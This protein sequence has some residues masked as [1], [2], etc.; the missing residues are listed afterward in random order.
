VVYDGGGA[1]GVFSRGRPTASNYGMHVANGSMTMQP[2]AKDGSNWFGDISGGRVFHFTM[3][4][5]SHLSNRRFLVVLLKGRGQA[6]YNAAPTKMHDEDLQ[7]ANRATTDA[8]LFAWVINGSNHDIVMY[9]NNGSVTGRPYDRINPLATG[10]YNDAQAAGRE[11]L[12]Q[13]EPRAQGTAR[14]HDKMHRFHLYVSATRFRIVEETPEGIY[15]VVVERDF[16]AGTVL[17]VGDQIE[18]VAVQ[19]LYHTGIDALGGEQYNSGSYP[20]GPENMHWIN[21]RPYCDER[22]WDNMGA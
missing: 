1:A 21:N 2:R 15:S 5:D 11:A 20:G 22:H 9:K 16:P 18:P 12:Y 6:L 19:E 10:D 4:V 13:T 7:P 14:E 8:N 3:E 17:S